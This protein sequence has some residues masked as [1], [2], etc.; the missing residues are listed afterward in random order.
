MVELNKVI[1]KEHGKRESVIDRKIK[2]VKGNIKSLTDI[3]EDPTHKN[4]K[5]GELLDR[6]DERRGEL[7]QLEKGQEKPGN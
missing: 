7:E 6:L 2:D 1:L 3:T 5:V 4:R